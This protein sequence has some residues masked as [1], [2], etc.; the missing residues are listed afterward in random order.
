MKRL[1]LV[2]YLL[3]SLVVYTEY[4]LWTWLSGDMVQF[5][6]TGLIVHAH[7]ILIPLYSLCSKTIFHLHL[8]SV[9]WYAITITGLAVAL[10]VKEW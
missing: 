8:T 3:T 1:L 5:R 10:Y 4:A 7:P 9:W 2:P 6:T